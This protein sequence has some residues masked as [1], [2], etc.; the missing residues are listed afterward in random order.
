MTEN[1]D[2]NNK[3]MA[4]RKQAK[5]ALFIWLALGVINTFVWFF[6]LD[7]KLHIGLGWFFF[8]LGAAQILVT[9]FALVQ[10]I[11]GRSVLYGISS[12]VLGAAGF[13][14]WIFAGVIGLGGFGGAW[15][16]PLRIA[17]KQL[18]PELR[19]GSDWTEG[20][21]PDASTL[22][23]ATS[24][25]LEALWLHDAQKEHASVPAFARVSWLLSAVGA[26]AELLAWAHRAG[27]EEIAHTRLCFALAAGYG[28]RSHTV[29]P[30][31]ELLQGGL[32]L[33]GNAIRTL[34]IESLTDGCQLE[35]FN[36]DVAAACAAVCEEPVT[37]RVLEQIAIEERSHAEFSWAVV[38]W[39]LLRHAST[40]VNA[41]S[42]ALVSLNKYPRPTAVARE[43]LPLVAKADKTAMRRHG[44]L[45]DSEWA[46][47][48]QTRLKKT[49]HRVNSLMAEAA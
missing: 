27:L 10:A 15:G 28:Q 39:L 9:L 6:W 49:Q 41:L 17:G 36:A 26:P 42:E 22:D 29:E 31:P 3:Y 12:V 1:A 19:E 5:V 16:R 37:R 7:R 35:D 2:L 34:A 46:E 38:D 13:F 14:T 33:A 8:F 11:R 18:H 20:D 32:G 23:T 21:Q 24:A 48:W 44:R 47:I 30:M 43:K 45:Q 25:A 40:T 4:L